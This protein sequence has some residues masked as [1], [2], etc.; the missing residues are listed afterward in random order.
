MSNDLELNNDLPGEEVFF[1][2]VLIPWE[3]LFDGTA[4]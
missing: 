3:M 4:R 2:D 1:I